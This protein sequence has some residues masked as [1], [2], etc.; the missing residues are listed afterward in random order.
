M[1]LCIVVIAL[2]FCIARFSMCIA[3]R[4]F[5]LCSV[6]LPNAFSHCVSVSPFVLPLSGSYLY[7]RIQRQYGGILF[8]F[9]GISPALLYV[10]IFIYKQLQCKMQFLVVIYAHR[11]ALWFRQHIYTK[12]RRHMLSVYT[13]SIYLYAFVYFIYIVDIAG[14]EMICT[15]ECGGSWRIY[16][17]V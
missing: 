2:G 4:C 11:A 5:M 8:L 15:T 9:W 1:C 6:S 12:E 7:S 17:Y 3:P 13:C 14:R 10:Y 16:E